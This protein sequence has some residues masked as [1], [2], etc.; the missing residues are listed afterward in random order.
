MFNTL[1]M[2]PVNISNKGLN[3]KNNSISL[4]I[5]SFITKNL[6][7]YFNNNIEKVLF[8]LISSIFTN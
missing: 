3:I 2:K 6:S 4:T 8:K 5:F 7:N 1:S